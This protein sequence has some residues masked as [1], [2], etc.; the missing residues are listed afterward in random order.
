VQQL[1]GK[2][3]VPEGEHV[4]VAGLGNVGYR[5]LDQ[6]VRAGTPAV[7]IDREPDG[8]FVESVPAGAA[9]VAGD[10]RLEATLLKAGTPS[11]HAV[12][13]ATG[14]DAANLSIAL[15]ARKLNPAVRTVVRLFD[16]DFARKVQTS[17]GVGAALSSS[18]LAAPTFVAAALFPDVKTAFVVD[19]RWLVAVRQVRGATY[20]DLAPAELEQREGVRLLLRR[21]ERDG[22]YRPADRAGGRIA[23]GE[24]LVLVERRR[25]DHGGAA[26]E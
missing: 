21:G 2:A 16:A 23:A 17:L 5:V 20:A 26:L 10:A 15:A 4:I 24:T 11:A 19:E 13:A 7:A 1:L 14:D 25:L 8:D 3:K 12:V 9:V 6:L 18:L 22:T